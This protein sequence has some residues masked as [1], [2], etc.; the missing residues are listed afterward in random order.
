MLDG[1][2]S[3]NALRKPQLL[4]KHSSFGTNA[5]A[6]TILQ[7][8]LSSVFASLYSLA[9]PSDWNDFFARNFVLNKKIATELTIWKKSSYY[10]QNCHFIV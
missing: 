8:V 5:K 2:N 3:F 9:S 4:H 10:I 1:T 7:Y 6:A